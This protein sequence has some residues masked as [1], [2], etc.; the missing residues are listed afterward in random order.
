MLFNKLNQFQ[1]NLLEF[2][3]IISIFYQLQGLLLIFQIKIFQNIIHIQKL[4]NVIQEQQLIQ[5]ELKHQKEENQQQFDNDDIPNN[6]LSNDA[7]NNKLQE[8]KLINKMFFER[9]TE[10][11]TNIRIY[12]IFKLKQYILQRQK[13]IYISLINY[14]L[15]KKKNLLYQQVIKKQKL[16]SQLIN[17]KECQRKTNVQRNE[18]KPQQSRPD[19]QNT[20]DSL[21]SKQNVNMNKNIFQNSNQKPIEINCQYSRR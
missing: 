4:L 2:F 7:D 12:H 18:K 11:D 13:I 19:L 9:F 6:L 17:K 3:F 8:Q 21:V 14:S 1:Q 20:F 15:Q 16:R 10:I 5:A